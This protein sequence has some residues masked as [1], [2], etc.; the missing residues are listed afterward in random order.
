MSAAAPGF[1]RK[2]FEF[3]GAPDVAPAAGPAE[4]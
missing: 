1:L 3:R 4:R 2:L